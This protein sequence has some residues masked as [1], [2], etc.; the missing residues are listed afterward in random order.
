[1]ILEQDF[2]LLTSVT[3]GDLGDSFCED[4]FKNEVNTKHEEYCPHCCGQWMTYLG[5]E[6]CGWKKTWEK[7]FTKDLGA[8]MLRQ[9]IT[10]M[11]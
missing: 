9:I 10:E 11:S 6:G 2:G 1:V 8:F 5:P 7:S 4:C 3:D